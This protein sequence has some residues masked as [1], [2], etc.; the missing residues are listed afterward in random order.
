[1]SKLP[2][3]SA[4]G[5][6]FIFWLVSGAGAHDSHKRINWKAYLFANPVMQNGVPVVTSLL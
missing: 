5:I 4:G 3:Y 1:M 2:P 6:E